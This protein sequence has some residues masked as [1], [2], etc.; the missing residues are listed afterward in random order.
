MYESNSEWICKIDKI[1]QRNRIITEER[2]VCVLVC[3]S[4]LLLNGSYSPNG[5]YKDLEAR[6]Y[7]RGTCRPARILSRKVW[8]QV[9]GI[10]KEKLIIL[11]LL[12]LIETDPHGSKLPQSYS[13]IET[14]MFQWLKS[15]SNGRNFG[16]IDF[17]NSHVETSSDVYITPTVW[18]LGT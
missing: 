8:V 14:L 13:A 4:N 6:K 1:F 11:C 2:F 3:V 9:E 10:F 5:I 7:T 18:I 12:E 15:N 17:W 16:L